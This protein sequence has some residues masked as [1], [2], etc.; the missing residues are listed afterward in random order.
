[1]S[2]V[3][4]EE[5]LKKADLPNRQS[6]SWHPFYKGKIEVVPKCKI[7]SI[8]DFGVWYTPGVAR[9]CKIIEEDI[10]KNNSYQK[11]YEHTGKWN[12]VAVVSDGSRVLGLGDIGPE[13]GMPVMEGKALLFK[14][15][16]GVD[17]YPI[18][19]DCHDAE[20]IIQTVKNIQPSF[21]GINLEDIAQPKCFEVLDTLRADKDLRIP[22]WHD[23][24][25]GT[26]A[27]TV[28]GVINAL[29]IVGKKKEDVQ[30][31]L[32]G[33][34]A[35]N[36]T[37]ARLIRSMG[38]PSRNLYL[39]DSRGILHPNREDKERLQKYYKQ[40]WEFALESN[41]EGRV[42]GKAEA[43]KG[44]DIVIAASKPG[45]GT[46]DPA[47]IKTM[48]DDAIVF[49]CANP[50]PELWPWEA[51]EAGVRVMGTGR[52]DFPNQINNSLGFPAIFRGTLDV[53]AVTITDTMCIAAS[54]EIARTAEFLAEERGT[55]ISEE[56]I[57]PT[58][59]DWQLFPREATA[60]A[61]QAIKEGVARIK[62]SRDEIYQ[63]AETII[64]RSQNL[65]KCMMENDFIKPAPNVE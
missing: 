33:A 8:D 25:Q 65:T 5:L 48:N 1:M 23:D 37:I 50:I 46:I 3:T 6:E 18:C 31:A 52:S 14:Y 7:D 2:K 57:V 17:A 42:G 30:I 55:Q 62:P 41:G 38:I 12:A 47:H 10:K 45:P 34:G 51:K 27:I 40:K 59:A 15:L 20:S 54:E 22:V 64:K 49:A 11:A 43:I 24:A 16:G 26:A 13:A 36:I 21:G 19:V 63:K 39:V 58:M 53:Q 61:M 60:V 44:V 32:I 56:Y 35:A 4:K 28:A 29:K 9:S